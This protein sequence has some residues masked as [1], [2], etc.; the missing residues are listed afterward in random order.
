MIFSNNNAFDYFTIAIM[1]IVMIFSGSVIEMDIMFNGL[2]MICFD[3]L[4]KKTVE[5]VE[6][7]L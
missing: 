6:D 3:C 4:L 2:Q 1:H 5:L 7:I